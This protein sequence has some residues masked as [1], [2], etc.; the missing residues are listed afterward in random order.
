VEIWTFNPISW[1]GEPIK[2]VGINFGAPGDRLAEN[3]TL[4]LDYPGVGGDSPEIP[5]SIVPEKPE[6]YCFHSSRIKGSEFN[7]VAASGVMGLSSVRITLAKESVK[8]RPYIVRLYFTEP[9]DCRPGER[10]FDVIIQGK[11][12]LRNFDIT[13]DAGEQN[14]LVMKEFRNIEIE[15]DLVIEFNPDDKTNTDVPVISGIEIL[16]QE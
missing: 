3:G 1:D 11:R 9:E 7:W 5:V 6:W 14:R 8:P 15:N 12:I 16:A 4:W 2:R 13:K 10:V